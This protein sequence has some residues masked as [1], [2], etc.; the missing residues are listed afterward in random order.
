MSRR[1]HISKHGVPAVCNSP[2]GMCSYG[3]ENSH[4]DTYEEAKVH[5]DKISESVKGNIMIPIES[6]AQKIRSYYLSGTAINEFPLNKKVADLVDFDL[7]VVSWLTMKEVKEGMK[8]NRIGLAKFTYG[9]IVR[10]LEEELKLKEEYKDGLGLENKYY[11]PIP[12]AYWEEQMKAQ[13]RLYEDSVDKLSEEL[14]FESMEIISLPMDAR[15]RLVQDGYLSSAE[16]LNEVVYKVAPEISQ[17]GNIIAYS[18][19][20]KEI[21]R[22]FDIYEIAGVVE[23]KSLHDLCYDKNID[24]KFKEMW[25]SKEFDSEGVDYE[26]VKEIYKKE[27]FFKGLEGTDIPRAL[28]RMSPIVA[29]EI[30]GFVSTHRTIMMAIGKIMDDKGMGD[31]FPTILEEEDSWTIK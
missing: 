21:S 13:K 3:D 17:F 7:V 18:H 24:T 15:R 2:A 1:F 28:M 14:G 10:V 30:A 8:N 26:T 5:V 20:T 29:K 27:Q 16:N 11:N 19:S 4:F 12:F 9:D 31:M 22:E 25:N 6:S 23:G